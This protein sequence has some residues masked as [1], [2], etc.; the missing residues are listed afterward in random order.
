MQ[1]LFGTH[2]NEHP[3]CSLNNPERPCGWYVSSVG[4]GASHFAEGWGRGAGF[5]SPT[6][7]R[8]RKRYVWGTR[9]N[10][11]LSLAGG[12]AVSEFDL[13]EF[14]TSV[15]DADCDSVE[16]QPACFVVTLAPLDLDQRGFMRAVVRHRLR[17]Q[18]GS[19]AMPIY[20]FCGER[21]T[22]WINYQARTY[23]MIVQPTNGRPAS[24]GRLIATG[25]TRRLQC[26]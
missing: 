8:P 16:V 18:Q 24:L 4:L 2:A 10:R 9:Q 17:V 20:F 3:L 12:F 23:R 22:P 7:H 15:K 13:D 19:R 21:R 5:D 1:F 26:A 25:D 14:L 11:R 6:I